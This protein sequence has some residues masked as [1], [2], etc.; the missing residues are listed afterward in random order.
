MVGNKAT[1][2]DI[3]QM[4]SSEWAKMLYRKAPTL[5]RSTIEFGL[6][7]QDQ[8]GDL[9]MPIF[10]IPLPIVSET[11]F[12]EFLHHYI[13]QCFD[14]VYEECYYNYRTI[15]DKLDDIFIIAWRKWKNTKRSNLY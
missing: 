11:H 5:Q 1:K 14:V 8:I 4:M 3:I 2:E 9:I 12:R 15:L 13:E 10:K 6:Q 7:V